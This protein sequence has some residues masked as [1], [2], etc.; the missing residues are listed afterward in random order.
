MTGAIR[1]RDGAAAAV[2][3]AAAERDTIQ[4]NLLELDGSL[5]KRLLAGAALAG[6]T[7]ARWART[8]H[9]LTAL[10]QTFTAY[11][12]VIDR[13]AEMAGGLG[14]SAAARIAEI[15]ALLSGPSVRLTRPPA[16]LG[17]R[18]LTADGSTELT[19]AAAIAEMRRSYASVSE[20]CAAAET[21]WTEMTARLQ[22]AAQGLASARD[23][24][25]GIGDEALAAALVTAEDTAATLRATLN[26]DPLALWQVSHVDA[27]LPDALDRQVAAAAARGTELAALRDGAVHRI[28]A[29]NAGL[30]AA[31]HAWLDA[32]DTQQRAASRIAGVS[33]RQ[34][35]DLDAL[36]ARASALDG[37]QAAGRW[38]RLASELAAVERDVARASA[39]ARAAQGAAVAQLA[40]RD[41]LR[42][43]L[44]AYRAK[45]IGR[46]GAEH[47]GLLAAYELARDLLWTA[48]CDLDAAAAAVQGYQQAVQA[49][50]AAA[51]RQP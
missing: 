35:P 25:S 49:L 31:R 4:A 43:L 51:G 29:V 30:A 47:P 48:P 22:R 33:A 26:R 2:R 24:A 6:Q 38:T 18:E 19:V 27:R 7:E 42:G 28:G 1:T 34:P 5:G 44:E 8:E 11:S 17:H 10:W 32:A 13:A 15:S 39:Q 3:A 12:T 36:A 46:G 45:A 50:P 14:R 37:L 40:R 23:A 9:E 21:V 20:V 41:E 16:P